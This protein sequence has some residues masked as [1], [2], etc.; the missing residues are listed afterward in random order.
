MARSPICTPQRRL[1][2]STAPKPFT[3]P[4]S[5]G[6]HRHIMPAV[7][8]TTEPTMRPET[9]PCVRPKCLNW[10]APA[11]RVRSSRSISSAVGVLTT[12]LFIHTGEHPLRRPQTRTIAVHARRQDLPEPCVRI[13]L[14]TH[15]DQL[16]TNQTGDQYK[17]TTPCLAKT[18]AGATSFR[19]MHTPP[20]STRWWASIPQHRK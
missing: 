7:I 9:M 19:A 8:P 10:H 13:I 4:R 14:M 12:R 6:W 3:A 11:L 16:G 1:P 17:N 18:R 5:S 15:T 2:N 20:S